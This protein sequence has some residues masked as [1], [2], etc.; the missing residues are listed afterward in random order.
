MLSAVRQLNSS[1]RRVGLHRTQAD[2]AI[3]RG[4]LLAFEARCR[5]V[6]KEFVAVVRG[7]GEPERTQ[8]AV[9]TAWDLTYLRRVW[10]M[11]VAAN[12]WPKGIGKYL[13]L[14]SCCRAGRG[15]GRVSD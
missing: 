15:R 10:G 6:A 7:L 2:P 13:E 12:G 11:E 3:V 8:V 4:L 9:Q 1:V 14:V 5:T